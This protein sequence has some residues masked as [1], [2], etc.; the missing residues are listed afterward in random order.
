M[1]TDV[2]R[3]Y[4][5]SRPEWTR[6]AVT[7]HQQLP[8]L[9]EDGTVCMVAITRR[10]FCPREQPQATQFHMASHL[11]FAFTCECLPSAGHSDLAFLSSPTTAGVAQ[12]ELAPVLASRPMLLNDAL[13]QSPIRLIAPP[14]FCRPPPLAPPFLPKSRLLDCLLQQSRLALS[15]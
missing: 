15:I 9:P 1:G 2:T 14:P 3:D 10:R 11:A 4:P 8:G 12:F 13:E 5:K 7:S 6:I